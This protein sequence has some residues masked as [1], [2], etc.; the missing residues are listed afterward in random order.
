MHMRGVL[1][2]CRELLEAVAERDAAAVAA[3]R[4]SDVVE[5]QQW[6]L[7]DLQRRTNG[8][9]RVHRAVRLLC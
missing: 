7:A 4:A 3:L 1:T 8:M 2:R 9:P 5:A 6:E